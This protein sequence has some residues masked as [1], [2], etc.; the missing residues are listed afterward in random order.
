MT[1]KY[2]LIGT[3]SHLGG[4]QFPVVHPHITVYVAL[5]DGHGRVDLRLAMV[6]VDEEHQVFEFR[7]PVEFTD[8]RNIIEVCFQAGR[9]EFHSPGEYRLMLFADDE[10]LMERKVFVSGPVAV[11]DS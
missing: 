1:S 9:L 11:S 8:P 4:L 6:D 2:T 5:T 3:F 10:I 7:G